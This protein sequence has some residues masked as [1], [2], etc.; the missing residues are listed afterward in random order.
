MSFQQAATRASAKDFPEPQRAQKLELYGLYKQ[1]TK[2]A[3]VPSQRPGF[4]DP[5][6]RAKFDAWAAR[7]GLAKADA[8]RE[9]IKL[10]QAIDPAFAPTPAAAVS[11]AQATAA[12]AGVLQPGAS[13]E[14]PPAA[15]VPPV[16]VGVV[17]IDVP[18]YTDLEDDQGFRY[19]VYNVRVTQSDGKV[20]AGAVARNARGCNRVGNRVGSARSLGN[21]LNQALAR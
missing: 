17:D 13:A 1:A 7:A 19:T 16:Q 2:G 3:A 21:G 9:Y 12:A 8:E 11:D 10:V 4:S 5:V 20:P 14:T 18:K 6:G 15:T